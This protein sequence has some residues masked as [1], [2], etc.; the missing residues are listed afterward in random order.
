MVPP[1]LMENMASDKVIP[2]LIK[3]DYDTVDTEI[4]HAYGRL[5]NRLVR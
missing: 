3:S 4:L 2:R 5:S 1:R